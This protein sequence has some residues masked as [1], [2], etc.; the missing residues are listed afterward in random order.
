MPPFLNQQVDEGPL[1][2]LNRP[3][4]LEA[5]CGG[6]H[7]GW[8]TGGG[9]NLWLETNALS[10]Y[11]QPPPP[12]PATIPKIKDCSACLQYFM[13]KSLTRKFQA[14]TIYVYCSQCSFF[15]AATL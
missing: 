1:I 4:R 12:P 15:C 8:I 13:D 10:A 5:V 9:I 2:L 14:E 3:L 6:L 11:P 7:G